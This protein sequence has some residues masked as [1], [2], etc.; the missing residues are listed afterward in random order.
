MDELFGESVK[1]EGKEQ[2]PSLAKT[3]KSR[4]SEP[5]SKKQEK[6]QRVLLSYLP[7]K[8][9]ETI[10]QKGTSGKYRMQGKKEAERRENRNDPVRNQGNKD[11]NQILHQQPQQKRK[12]KERE[13][14]VNFMDNSFDS[15]LNASAV[16]QDE[17]VQAFIAESRN[18]R[19]RC[20]ELSE[21]VTA[22]SGNGWENAAEVSGCTE[23]L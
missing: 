22:R 7:R 13:R 15:L 8:T 16:P 19:N 6:P 12:P 17:K 3:T 11:R 9:R 1:K 2:N 23:Y 21:Q 14:E 4:L 18:N 5:T 10:G 20:Y